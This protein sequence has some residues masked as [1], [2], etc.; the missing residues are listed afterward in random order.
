MDTI[1]VEN[2]A[3][4]IFPTKMRVHPSAIEFNDFE[5]GPVYVIRFSVQNITTSSRRFRIALPKNHSLRLTGS[6]T[7]HQLAPGVTHYLDIEFQPT[8]LIDI[9]DMIYVISEKETI[10][11]TVRGTCI[12]NDF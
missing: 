2:N 4:S 1:A 3:T 10:P 11:V 8:A 5:I 6:T 9:S 7:E 12:C